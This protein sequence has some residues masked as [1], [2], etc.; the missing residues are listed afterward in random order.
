MGKIIEFPLDRV[1]RINVPYLK[2][3]SSARQLFE[4]ESLR[5]Y[6]GSY[7]L[8][9]KD[10]KRR[11]PFRALLNEK[12]SED[13]IRFMVKGVRLEYPHERYETPKYDNS[14]WFLLSQDGVELLAFVDL[15]ESSPIDNYCRFHALR[16]EY[17][18]VASVTISLPR[19]RGIRHAEIYGIHNHSLAYNENRE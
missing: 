6:M 4:C 14:K 12:L 2:R 7:H 19:T 16:S 11:R 13:W 1:R 8:T 18:D 10:V 5:E 3:D 15:S 9:A 17:G